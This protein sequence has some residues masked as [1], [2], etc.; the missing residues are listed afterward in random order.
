MQTHQPRRNPRLRSSQ[1]LFATLALILPAAV[2]AEWTDITDV[3]A[4]TMDR[5][6]YNRI[7][8]QTIS[9]VSVENGA[10]PFNC[11][12]RVVLTDSNQTL[13]NADGITAATAP[14]PNAPYLRLAE[15]GLAAVGCATTS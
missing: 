5:G 15:D 4:S 14:N 12:L 6:I 2:A 8:R 3:V 10:V 11:R 9:T 13:S 7:A 1:R